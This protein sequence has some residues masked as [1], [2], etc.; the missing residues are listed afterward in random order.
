MVW[1]KSIV[2][3]IERLDLTATDAYVRANLL[4]ILY[5]VQPA[6]PYLR[7][8]DGTSL[9]RIVMVSSGASTKGYSAWGLYSMVKS[10]MN[11]LARTLASEEGGNGIGVWAVRP[12]LIDVSGFCGVLRGCADAAWFRPE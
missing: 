7:R 6:L 10:G 12:G 4:S 5:M 3:R 9:G 8:Q 11:S 2:E 1:L